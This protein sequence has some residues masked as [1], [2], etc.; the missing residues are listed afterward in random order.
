[1]DYFYDH[2][3]DSL[4]LMLAEFLDFARAEQVAPGVI[5]YLDGQRSVIAI[6]IC[7]AGKILDTRGLSPMH[8]RSITVLELQKRLSVSE[9]GRIAWRSV[10]TM[11][12]RLTVNG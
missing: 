5:A 9:V 4:S 10:M 3:T 1:M 11:G 2:E 6:E 8:A 12:A 7:G